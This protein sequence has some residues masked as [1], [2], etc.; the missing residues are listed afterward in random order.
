MQQIEP[1]PHQSFVLATLEDSTNNRE[2]TRNDDDRDA[3][4][5]IVSALKFRSGRKQATVACYSSMTSITCLVRA[6]V[7]ARVAPPIIRRVTSESCF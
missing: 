6:R 7:T 5:W 1:K 3:D 4:S 2:M